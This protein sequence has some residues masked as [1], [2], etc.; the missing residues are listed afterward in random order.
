[1]SDLLTKLE[2]AGGS[3]LLPGKATLQERAA[4]SIHL[5]VLR[6]QHHAVIADEVFDENNE[7]QGVRC[8]HFLTCVACK[9]SAR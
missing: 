2:R 4:L 6:A 7:S 3:G 5:S 8:W 1:M 9:E